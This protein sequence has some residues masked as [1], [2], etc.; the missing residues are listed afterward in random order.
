MTTTRSFNDVSGHFAAID[1]R[2][3]TALSVAR[4]KSGTNSARH[5]DPS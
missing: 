1:A 5:A 2:M 3:R 4:D